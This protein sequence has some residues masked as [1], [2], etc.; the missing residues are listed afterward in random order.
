MQERI[1]AVVII[2]VVI[3]ALVSG[4][5]VYV[6]SNKATAMIT[7]Y[8]SGSDQT[9]A[10]MDQSIKDLM[11][12]AVPFRKAKSDV[13]NKQ[14]KNGLTP[15]HWAAARGHVKMAR[16]LIAE[17]ASI[18]TQDRSRLTPLHWA[19][20]NGQLEV[21]KVLLKN[22]ADTDTF[23]PSGNTAYNL[24]VQNGHTEVAKLLSNNLG[25]AD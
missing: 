14:D 15:L 18:N 21:V 11:I 12:L 9:D 2:I 23:D 5:Y 24:A 8:P 20:A 6:A 17:G 22:H 25:T 10:Q 4:V 16:L 13:V 19:A 1:F 7:A 3:A